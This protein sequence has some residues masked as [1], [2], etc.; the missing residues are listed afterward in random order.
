MFFLKPSI[1]EFMAYI[2]WGIMTTLVNIISFYFLRLFL[3]QYLIIS[4]FLAWILTI[5]FAFFSNRSY[6]FINRDKTK[7]ITKE[8]Y[9]FFGCRFLTGIVDMIV[10]IIGI[11]YMH[12]HEIMTKV[13][14]NIIVIIANYVLSKLII[15]KNAKD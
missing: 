14:A 2:F 10:I 13:V 15:F 3:P 11:D 7:N 6:V 4:N 8:F 9:Q 1:K 12:F 5:I